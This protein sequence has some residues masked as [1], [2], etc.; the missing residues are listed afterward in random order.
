[1]CIRDRTYTLDGKKI[2]AKDLKEKS[3]HLV[4]R[5]QYENTTISKE[6]YVPFLMVTG[7]IFDTDKTVSYTHLIPSSFN[8]FVTFT[9]VEISA[10]S[11]PGIQSALYPCILSVSYTHLDVYKRQI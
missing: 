5:Y 6:V 10:W 3:G 11:V 9:S 7:L 4:A 8:W 1:M 2:S